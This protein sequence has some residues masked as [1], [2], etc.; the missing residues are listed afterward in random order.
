VTLNG[1]P[2]GMAISPPYLF[3]V[4]KYLQPGQNVL[5][6]WITNVAANRIRDMDRRGVKWKIF[7][8]PPNVMSIH[9]KPLDASGWPV[10]DAGLLGPV[11]LIPENDLSSGGGGG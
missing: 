8:D 6:F 7:H 10:R 5:D 9:H 3:H 2:I 1:Q 11:R 4:E